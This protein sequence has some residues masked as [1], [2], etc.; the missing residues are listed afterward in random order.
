MASYTFATLNDPL[1]NSTFFGTFPEDIND[2]GQITGFYYT[3][4]GQSSFQSGFL[5][6]NGVF[7]TFSVPGAFDTNAAG[8]NDAGQIVGTATFP[9]QPGQFPTRGFLYSNGVF[10]VL[11]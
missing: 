9:G 2:T 8:I 6:S 1:Q 11:N 7:T 3:A 10:T 4:P 5:F